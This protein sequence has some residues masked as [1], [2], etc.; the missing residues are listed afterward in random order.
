MD[1][2]WLK[3]PRPGCTGSY[4]VHVAVTGAS[5]ETPGVTPVIGLNVSPSCGRLSE[6]W[7][8][9]VLVPNEGDQFREDNLPARIRKLRMPPWV[10]TSLALGLLVLAVAIVAG[11]ILVN[12]YDSTIISSRVEGLILGAAIV[13]AIFG[14]VLLW[15]AGEWVTLTREAAFVTTAFFIRSR[16]DR[17]Q[18]ED[19]YPYLHRLPSRGGPQYRMVPTFTVRDTRDRLRDVPLPFLSYWNPVGGTEAVLPPRAAF[20]A[21][22]ARSVSSPYSR[23][24]ITGAVPGALEMHRQSVRTGLLRRARL[25]AI[26]VPVVSI[27]LGLGLGFGFAPASKA[28]GLTRSADAQ[29]N[30]TGTRDLDDHLTPPMTAYQWRAKEI[31]PGTRDFTFFPTMRS[32]P[33]A[34]YTVRYFI[35]DPSQHGPDLT[36]PEQKYGRIVSEGT[37]SAQNPTIEFTLDHDDATFTFEVYVTDDHGHT[38]LDSDLYRNIAALP[39]T[40]KA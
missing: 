12:E 16:V 11:S 37:I 36:G 19:F 21:A 31:Q 40:P 6:A 25:V 33:S 10:A 29:T 18:L 34:P 3:I 9:G 23:A 24:A 13:F 7:G 22:W 28:L 8:C 20:I 4:D 17:T 14:A 1:K 27:G 30:R 32:L 5:R 38:T 15:H 39:T 2:E 26:L 35:R